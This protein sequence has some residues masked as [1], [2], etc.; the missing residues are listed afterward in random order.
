L[1]VPFFNINKI[2]IREL[3]IVVISK[4]SNN[5]WISTKQQ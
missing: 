3:L 2:R 1:L 5:Q 4:T